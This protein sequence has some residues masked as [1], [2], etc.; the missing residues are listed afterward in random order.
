M[1][2]RRNIV[3]MGAL[4]RWR[5]LR[6]RAALA[7]AW[8]FVLV[9]FAADSRAAGPCTPDC[10]FRTCGLDPICAT[11]CGTCPAD[12][13]CGPVGQCLPAASPDVDAS[14]GDFDAGVSDTDGGLR[15]VADPKSSCSIE[16]RAVGSTSP[17]A[18][19]GALLAAVVA[20]AGRRLR[21]KRRVC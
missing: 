20:T 18:L 16:P 13:T 1:T 10:S 3:F 14:G 19:L 5:I 12:Q 21:R 4:F 2:D 8:V 15:E 17:T 9:S 11:S 6:L 7:V